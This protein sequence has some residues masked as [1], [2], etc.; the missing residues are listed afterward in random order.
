MSHRDGTGALPVLVVG[1]V[2]F[3]LAVTG[4]AAWMVFRGTGTTLSNRKP[5]PEAAPDTAETEAPRPS[6]AAPAEASP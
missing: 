2:L 6:P 5:A 3:G 4:I 1:A